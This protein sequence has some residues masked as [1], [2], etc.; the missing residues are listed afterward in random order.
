MICNRFESTQGSRTRPTMPKAAV[1]KP[2][3][4]RDVVAKL[5]TYHGTPA[6]PLTT[7][8][9]EAAI[10]ESVAYLVDDDRRQQVFERLRHTVGITPEDLLA[11]PE[12]ELAQLI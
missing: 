1:P 10:L 5:Q 8:P 9:L 11:I 3:D 2:P 4:L 6:P 7:D 12:E